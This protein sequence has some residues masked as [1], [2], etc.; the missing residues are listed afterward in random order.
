MITGTA[1]LKCCKSANQACG[2]A[3]CPVK[4]GTPAL[5]QPKAQKSVRGRDKREAEYAKSHPSCEV[6]GRATQ[7]VHHQGGRKLG[8]WR[9]K[10]A[11]LQA[12]CNDCHL[13]IHSG[14]PA[15]TKLQ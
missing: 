8:G 5:G 10:T 11:P 2:L 6:C 12:L 15:T 4:R 9:R 1:T 14:I 7:A 13:R 3:L